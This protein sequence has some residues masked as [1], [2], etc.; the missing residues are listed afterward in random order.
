VVEDRDFARAEYVEQAAAR[1]YRWY[2]TSPA[3]STSTW[4][5]LMI[6]TAKRVQSMGGVETSAKRQTGKM[7]DTGS[8]TLM[9]IAGH[10]SGR[11]L[12][13]DTC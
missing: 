5:R 3:N 6:P 10:A 11:S 4:L 2:V 12:G 1:A 9:T 8:S 7:V 13:V